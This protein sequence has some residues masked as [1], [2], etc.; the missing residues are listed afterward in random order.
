MQPN[1]LIRSWQVTNEDQ[2]REVLRQDQGRLHPKTILV[3]QEGEE[4]QG[5][6]D[7]VQ[8]ED[9]EAGL[10]REELHP[11]DLDQ[12]PLEDQEAMIVG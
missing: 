5:P 12:D 3:V 1:Y 7:Q 10:E 11:Q 4:R 2:S 8:E 9:P 6:Q